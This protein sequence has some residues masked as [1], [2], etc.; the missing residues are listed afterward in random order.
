MQTT[1]K[2]AADLHILFTALA[3]AVAADAKR[4][5]GGRWPRSWASTFR[6]DGYRRAWWRRDDWS[7]PI[8]RLHRDQ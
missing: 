2:K 5:D 7:H 4:L 8:A 3:A 1:K 6:L